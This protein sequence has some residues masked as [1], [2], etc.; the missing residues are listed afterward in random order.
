MIAVIFSTITGN[1]YK[2]AEAAASVVDNKVG[3]YNIAYITDE[4]IEKFDTFIITYWCDKGNAD[5]DVKNLI[6]KMKD[7]N[8]IILGTIGVEA[9]SPYALSTAKRVEELVSEQNNL[10]G[11]FLCRGSIDLMRTV[12]KLKIPEGERGRL[13]P[14]MFQSYI[15]SAGHPTAYDLHKAADFTAKILAKMGHGDR[16]YESGDTV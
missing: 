15:Q 12:Q 8:I 16:V 9:N 1:G 14:E 2:L 7:K 4:V 11:H 3:P 10:L 13:S 6:A 5:A